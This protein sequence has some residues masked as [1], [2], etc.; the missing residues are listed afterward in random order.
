MQ[1]RGAEKRKSNECDENH[2]AC[3]GGWDLGD[4]TNDLA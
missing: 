1:S 4:G 2:F 3:C